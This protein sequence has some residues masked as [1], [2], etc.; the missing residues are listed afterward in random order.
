MFIHLLITPPLVHRGR[1]QMPP[2]TAESGAPH[3]DATTEAPR[4]TNPRQSIRK[5][6]PSQ[7][8]LAADAISV[9]SDRALENSKGE[10]IEEQGE[11]TQTPAAPN[12]QGM[13]GRQ[14]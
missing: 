4:P 9:A 5:R 10:I 14:G 13:A 8:A 6:V 11:S 12:G 2:G 3:T 7:R 1:G